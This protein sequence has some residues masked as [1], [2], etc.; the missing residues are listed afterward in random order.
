MTVDAGPGRHED[1]SFLLDYWRAR[2]VDARPPLKARMD[3]ADFPHLLARVALIEAVPRGDA[4]PGG[5]WT[6]R[7]RLAGEEIVARA[8]RDPRGKSFEA[9]YEGDYLAA[10]NA[11]YD[12]LRA[13]AEPHLSRNVFPVDP[14]SGARLAY[15]RLILPLRSRGGLTDPDLFLLLIV[16]IDQTGDVERTGS[17][18]KARR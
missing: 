13:S 8:G 14:R 15:D 18:L 7:Y 17:F 4:A 10:A 16:A 2:R 1:Q 11:L 12:R 6:Y 5:G 9:L 3:P